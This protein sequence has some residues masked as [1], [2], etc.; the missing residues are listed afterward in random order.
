MV[1]FYFYH[2]KKKR[3]LK[4]IPSL[5]ISLQSSKEQ[6]STVSYLI[7]EVSGFTENIGDDKNDST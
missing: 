3:W 7:N 5:L 4:H 6:P 2:R 1:V